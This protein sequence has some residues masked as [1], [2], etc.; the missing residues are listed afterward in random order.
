[1]VSSKRSTANV[2]R[3]ATTHP[4]PEVASAPIPL[5]LTSFALVAISRRT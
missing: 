4:Q 3:A 5:G 2:S 1:M